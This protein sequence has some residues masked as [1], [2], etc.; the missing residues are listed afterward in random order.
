[1]K[2]LLIGFILIIPLNSEAAC[3]WVWVDHDFNASTPAIRQQVC[4]NTYDPPS[5]NR[6]SIQPIQRP[7]IRPIETPTIPPIG[8][9]RCRNASVYNEFTRR[10]ETKRVCD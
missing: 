5:I 10:W 9:T 1:M 2:K 4:D 7:Q 8:T 3:R 6:P